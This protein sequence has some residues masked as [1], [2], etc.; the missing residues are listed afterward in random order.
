M[1]VPTH[2]SALEL[3]WLHSKY[4]K[5]FLSPQFQ[6]RRGGELQQALLPGAAACI[7]IKEEEKDMRNP[8]RGAVAG[9]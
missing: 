6:V 8:S 1:K 4:G 5:C 2:G 3:M 9:M 7:R